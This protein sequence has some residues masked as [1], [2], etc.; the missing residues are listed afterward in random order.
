MTV[1][2]PAVTFP[3]A[4]TGRKITGYAPASSLLLIMAGPV[5]PP[6]G[7][8]SQPCPPRWSRDRSDLWLRNAAAGLCVL[9]A[10]AAAVSF[11]ASGDV[12]Y[13]NCLNA[14]QVGVGR[15]SAAG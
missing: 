14:P 3:S 6:R 4:G 11:S 5:A 2:I 13:C 12:G 1:A 9:A 15:V 7:S 8:G 10:A